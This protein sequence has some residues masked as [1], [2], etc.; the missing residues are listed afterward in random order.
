MT[1]QEIHTGFHQDQSVSDQSGL[2]A[3][4]VLG[5][6]VQVLDHTGQ[7]THSALTVEPLS[8]AWRTQQEQ[9]HFEWI[10][11]TKEELRLQMKILNCLKRYHSFLLYLSAC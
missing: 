6:L 10:N 1:I 7:P 5:A 3:V 11:S 2:S 4:H 9:Q 8:A